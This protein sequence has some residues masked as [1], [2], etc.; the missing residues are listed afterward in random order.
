V[1]LAGFPI[2]NPAMIVK[3]SDKDFLEAWEK[4]KSP[5][6]LAKLFK[7]SERRVHSRR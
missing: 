5:A 6:A 7:M 3:V 4:H 2:R 1:I